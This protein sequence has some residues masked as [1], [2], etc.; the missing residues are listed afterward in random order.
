MSD[1]LGQT[2]YSRFHEEAIT[3]MRLAIESAGGNE[4]FF[5][6]TLSPSGMVSEV[7]VCA[8]G[9]EGAVPA[10]F[11]GLQ[12]RDIVIH[13][14]P[15]G[16]LTPSEADLN[17]AATYSHNGHGVYIVDNPV[18]HVY[19]VIE[20]FLDE[21]KT[22]LNADSLKKLLSDDSPL[23]DSLASFE[24]RP[25]QHEM[26]SVVAE[27]FNKNAIALI[28]APTGVGKT[29]AYLIPAV[30][31]ALQNKERVVISTRTINLQEQIIEKDIPLLQQVI[32][33]PFSAVLVKGRSNYVC[34]RR[35]ERAR[36]EAALFDD[37]DGEQR[38]IKDIAE[39]A[40]HTKD[41]STADL[42]FVPSRAVWEKVCS[43]SDTCTNA[44]CQQAG[45]CF[46]TKARRDIAKADI[47]VVNH[48]MLF[49]DMAIKKEMGT[50]TSLAVLP[51]FE[52]LIID[53]AH[54]IE[55]SATEYFGNEVTQLGMQNLFGRFVR[56]ER[57]KDRGLLPLLKLKLIQHAQQIAKNEQE[58]LLDVIDNTLIPSLILTRD[59]LIAA[60][61]AIRNLT[62][63]NCK[64]VGR[65][66]KWRLTPEHIQS[67][68]LRDIHKTLV[69]PSVEEIH[70]VVAH[71]NS[72]LS[73]LRKI[74][75]GPMDNENPLSIEMTQLTSY[76]DRMIRF[77]NNMS[78]ATSSKVDPGMVPWI[79]IDGERNHIVRIVRCPLHV[80]DA[81]VEWVY[82][83]LKSIA[84]ASATLSVA[85]SFDFVFDRIGLDK[86]GSRPLLTKALDSPFDFMEQ[87]M[88][89]MPNDL[90][91]PGSPQFMDASTDTIGEL[92]RLSKGHAFVLFTSYYAMNVTFSKLQGQLREQG[93]T[94][95]K[96]GQAARNVLL[97]RFRADPSSVLF[98][99][100]SF[101]EGVDV[102]GESLQCVIMPKLPFRVPTEPVFQARAEQIDEQ[103]GS[104]FH[105]YTMPLAVIKFRQGFGRLI[106][107]KSDRGVVVVLDPRIKQKSYGKL[108]LRSLPEMRQ[109]HDS[110]AQI[111][112]SIRDFFA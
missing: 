75:F 21:Q 60:F 43:D 37:D 93:I 85:G 103:G 53:E 87:A 76:R 12:P 88:F 111:Y 22:A 90:P 39:W 30:Q 105:D 71:C 108:F 48:H 41:G 33:E 13:N 84:M 112:T 106:R 55:D 91:D 25:Q 70:Q 98:G 5:S 36:S 74:D 44:Q 100:D 72:V 67:K 61:Q 23:K 57:G 45:N 31:W 24:L 50:F 96:Q 66:V 92:I 51:A 15:S 3:Q 10:I 16:N 35:L 102:A 65:D 63:E 99:T 78:E 97:D 18:E 52:R 73:K 32:A 56:S 58:A 79:E 64:Q 17:L 49:S 47:I 7:R 2:S 77:A 80:G 62:A 110:S 9:H 27:S 94:P 40:E 8:R 6:G 109:E 46:L 19:V 29:L 68:E 4:V 82:P 59:G 26:M 104:S 11:E 34:K 81:L 83:N 95:L 38:Q 20:P 107:R 1:T 14:H 101:W 89:C 28:E 42:S 86:L 69:M 54:H